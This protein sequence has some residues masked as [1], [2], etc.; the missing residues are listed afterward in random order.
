[1][2]TVINTECQRV[3]TGKLLINI[4]VSETNNE[5]FRRPIVLQGNISSIAFNSSIFGKMKGKERERERSPR[6]RAHLGSY[7][8]GRA[9][10]GCAD[11]QD[12]WAGTVLCLSP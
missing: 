12:A 5:K 7:V 1:M 3:S 9:C 4:H 6:N 10:V 11:W 2:I 8:T